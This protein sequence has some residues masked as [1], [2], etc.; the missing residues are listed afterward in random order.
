MVL[1]T[2]LAVVAIV[3][4]GAAWWLNRIPVRSVPAASA[5][6]PSRVAN[7]FNSTP[8]IASSS[9]NLSNTVAQTQ[10]PNAAGV[11]QAGPET[12]VSKQLGLSFQYWQ[13]GKIL[14]YETGTILTISFPYQGGNTQG[15]IQDLIEMFGKA[16][17][18]S[19]HQSVESLLSSEN[20]AGCVAE[21]VSS[22]A[23]YMPPAFNQQIEVL[24]NSA[25]TGGCQYGWIDYAANGDAYFS[26]NSNY[27]DRFYFYDFGQG[28][29]PNLSD[30]DNTDGGDWRTTI[31]LINFD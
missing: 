17:Q 10:S 25:I 2:A 5:T 6:G 19:F 26:Y 16:P 9:S 4:I 11:G 13:D 18:E 8:G 28:G 30:P 24:S 21:E 27:P 14:I 7:E 23:A 12:Y 3:V 15:D 31:Q 29:Y 1:L 22:S 20:I